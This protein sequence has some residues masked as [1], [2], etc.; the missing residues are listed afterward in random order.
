[1]LPVRLED[2]IN[3]SDPS[4]RSETRLVLIRAEIAK[5]RRILFG[6]DKGHKGLIYKVQSLI[7]SADR[8]YFIRRVGLWC[9]VI[10]VI[11]ATGIVQSKRILWEYFDRLRIA[12][13]LGHRF[14][15]DVGH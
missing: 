4:S 12:R 7:K 14:R 6:D 10:I 8:R 3:E 9:A 13:E 11:L 1:M 5:I 15:N 2:Q